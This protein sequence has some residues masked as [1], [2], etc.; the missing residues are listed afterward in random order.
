MKVPAD[1]LTGF[2]ADLFRAAGLTEASAQRVAEV[3]VGADLQGKGSHG[4]LQAEAY[5]ARLL[6]GSMTAAE[7]LEIVSDNG[8]AVVVDAANMFGHLAAEQAMEIA[9]AHAKDHGMAIVAM[10]RGF[11]FGVAG[12]YALMAAN[13]GC[14]GIVMCN[15][16]SIMPPPGGAEKLVGTN[17]LAIAVPT[18]GEPAIVHDMATTAGSIG[19]IRQYLAA[20]QPIPADWAVDADGKPTTDAAEAMKG[21]LLPTGGAKGFGLAL[22]IDLLC[23]VLASGGWGPTLGEMRGDLTKPYNGSS[24]FMAIDV[25]RFRPLPEF[26]AETQAAAERVRK[27]ARAPG[28]DRLY[29]PGERSWESQ[30]RSAGIATISPA[31]AKSLAEIAEKLGVPPLVVN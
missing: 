11:H 31:V 24:L 22:V 7:R 5:I 20:G 29:T 6:S 12:H 25:A 14:V 23:G 18:A 9:I 15:T 17:P 28:V 21:S 27:A 16:R 1:R 4:V 30:R 8:T 3:L 13:A 10:R 26:L 19:K 2:T